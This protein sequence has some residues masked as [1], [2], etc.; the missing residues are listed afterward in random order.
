[1]QTLQTFNKSGSWEKYPVNSAC[2]VTA[3]HCHIPADTVI[4]HMQCLHSQVKKLA[5]IFLWRLEF[6]A[7]FLSSTTNS[8]LN[9]RRHLISVAYIKF[10]PLFS[11]QKGFTPSVCWA[12]FSLWFLF[13]WWKKS[14]HQILLHEQP[15]SLFCLIIHCY[16]IQFQCLGLTIKFTASRISFCH[17]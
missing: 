6:S 1:M 13:H 5:Y 4:H 11:P 17:Y 12:T 9:V 15:R 10:P 8:F 3:L 16:N 14:H 7:S 2:L